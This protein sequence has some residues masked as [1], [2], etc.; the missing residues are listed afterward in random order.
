[1]QA[2]KIPFEERVPHVLKIISEAEK[3]IMHGEI[4]AK[5]I[6]ETKIKVSKHT[7]NK[8]LNYLEFTGQ[9]KK[10]EIKG[11]GNPCIYSANDVPFSRKFSD[12]I[13]YHNWFFRQCIQAGNTDRF[14]KMHYFEISE[15]IQFLLDALIE[16]LY[17]YS[18]A[19][20]RKDA[21][22]RYKLFLES[23][24]LPALLKL[25]EL[26][27]PP[28]TMSEET[29][30]LLSEIFRSGTFEK[31][32]K[33]SHPLF[34]KEMGAFLGR[35]STS[36]ESESTGPIENLVLRPETL[37]LIENVKELKRLLPRTFDPKTYCD[38]M[39]KASDELQKVVGR[40]SK[41]RNEN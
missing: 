31:L 12:G 18:T 41:K 14:E 5:L 8:C 9:I 30:G 38:D 7:L 36:R 24:F 37:E 28:L 22:S 13:E 16:E 11:R 6:A 39:S 29:R 19:E 21:S 32:V 40:C 20:K 27:R 15:K 33:T 10:T 23:Q 3:P 2:S 17:I 35:E 34:R 1:M 4:H 26:V 25:K